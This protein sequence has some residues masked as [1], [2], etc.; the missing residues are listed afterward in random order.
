MFTLSTIA[1]A[2]S[3]AYANSVFI[4]SSGANESSLGGQ[5]WGSQDNQT[6]APTMGTITINPFLT[7]ASP[8]PFYPQITLPDPRVGEL[9]KKLAALEEMV[10]KLLPKVIELS[11]PE[12]SDDKRIV[13][14]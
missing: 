3:A 4:S 1:A 9:E 11:D 2:N 5:W 8:N 10:M 14:L 13:E 12:E 6:A 7:P